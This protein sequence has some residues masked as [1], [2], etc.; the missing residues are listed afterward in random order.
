[1]KHRIKVSKDETL[2]VNDE[3]A[4]NTRW[5]VKPPLAGEIVSGEVGASIRRGVKGK[6]QHGEWYIDNNVTIPLPGPHVSKDNPRVEPV[7]SA[8]R[9]ASVLGPGRILRGDS[10]LA[11]VND[12]WY[13]ALSEAMPKGYYMTMESELKPLAF[14]APTGDLCALL[15]PVRA[16]YEDVW[17]QLEDVR[18]ILDAV[19]QEK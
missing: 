2:L 16:L 17:S 6:Y 19:R 7:M 3:W 8:F 15:M 4:T 9:V 18:D 13:T 12:E 5:A 11:V 1:M 10:F 14:W